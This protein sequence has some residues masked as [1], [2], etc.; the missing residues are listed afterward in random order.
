MVVLKAECQVE[1]LV[2]P[3]EEDPEASLVLL[4]DLEVRQVTTMDQ[5]LRR[6]TR[7]S[8]FSSGDAHF[9]V[10]GF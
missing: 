9:F 1:C 2:C 4:V 8:T 5:L 7:C 10:Y 3:V 6:L